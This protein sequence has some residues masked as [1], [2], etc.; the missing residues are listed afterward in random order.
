MPSSTIRPVSTYDNLGVTQQR[1]QQQQQQAELELEPEL[2]GSGTSHSI[3]AVKA[4]LNDAKSKFFGINNYE[5]PPVASASAHVPAIKSE[6]MYQ[7]L[8]QH[9]PHPVIKAAPVPAIVPVTATAT[10]PAGDEAPLQYVTT[11]EQI[12]LSDLDAPQPS[13]AVYM[14]TTVPQNM[15]GMKIAGRH[16]PTRN[17][18]RHSRMIVVNHKNH[19]SLQAAYSRHIRNLN[20]SRQLLIMQLAVGLLI[21]GLAVWIL[22]L[23]PNASI[24]I[25]PYLSGLSL[26]LA[27]IAGLILHRR[28]AKSEQHRPGNSCYKVLL[29]ESYVFSAL[30][31]IFC[32]LALVCAA[33]EFAEL[34]SSPSGEGACG[35]AT[36]SLL[37]YQNCTCFSE[38]DEDAT[39]SPALA[40]EEASVQKDTDGCGS[41]RL[42]WK[43]LLAF[44]MALN[45]LGIVATFLYITLFIC[46]RSNNRKHF[47]TSV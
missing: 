13:Q 43:Y 12:P 26:L 34:T 45:T 39:P 9:D 6:P 23:A 8:L 28:N 42:K 11:Y 40:L 37:S 10:A 3:A 44:S 1:Q 41:I 5:S 14:S 38:G 29:A 30:T 47:Y 17:S 20:I 32:C 2:N 18:L 4:A 25:N 35:P 21:T 33:I 15:K 46:C 22:I 36:S 19:D 7:N 31:L 16:T 27:S 24:L